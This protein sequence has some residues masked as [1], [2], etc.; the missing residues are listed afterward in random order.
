MNEFE[1]VANLEDLYGAYVSDSERELIA[2]N[3]EIGADDAGAQYNADDDLYSAP[4][5]TNHE[6]ELDALLARF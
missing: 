5:R 2:L 6:E 3:E 4:V 1:A